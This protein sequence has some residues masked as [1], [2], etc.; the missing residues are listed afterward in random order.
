MF[1]REGIFFRILS[2]LCRLYTQECNPA[3][4]TK[5]LDGYIVCDV[6][7]IWSGLRGS[8][9]KQKAYKQS[10]SKLI[11]RW[12]LYFFVLES[13]TNRRTGLSRIFKDV[14]N[15]FL[16]NLWRLF[17]HSWFILVEEISLLVG[18][19]NQMNL[20]RSQI[21]TEKSKQTLTTTT[22]TAN[23]KYFARFVCITK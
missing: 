21:H 18:K 3:W 7:G 15:G 14:K 19:C 8:M 20:K 17:N 13:K 9:A 4:K 5:I 16:L 1:Y 12:A 6:S 11:L 2:S 23:D 10:N 22:L